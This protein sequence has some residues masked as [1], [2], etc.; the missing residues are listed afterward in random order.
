MAMALIWITESKLPILKYK[1]C[2]HRLQPNN[3]QQIKAVFKFYL[4]SMDL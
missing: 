1:F 3:K 4:S 2:S